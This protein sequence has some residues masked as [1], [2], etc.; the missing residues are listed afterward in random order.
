[1]QN[2][3]VEQLDYATMQDG[4]IRIVQLKPDS[5]LGV[6]KMKWTHNGKILEYKTA[7]GSNREEI[8]SQLK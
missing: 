5:F 7:V 3:P 8:E 4:E 1:M 2:N 6:R